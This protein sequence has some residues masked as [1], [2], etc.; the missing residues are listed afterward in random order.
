LKGFLKINGRYL[1][2]NEKDFNYYL[3]TFSF[4]SAFANAPISVCSWNLENFGKSKSDTTIEF[5]AN[6]IKDYD[7]VAIQEVVAG[8][9]GSQA[10]A[11]LC[12]VLNRKGAKWD[13]TVSDP[14][15]SNNSYK[16]ERYAFIWKTSKLKK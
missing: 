8:Y 5:I 16:V 12:D 7:V 3:F 6:T 9:G 11:K 13:Y 10:V 2:L 1:Q 4:L 15:S 14:T